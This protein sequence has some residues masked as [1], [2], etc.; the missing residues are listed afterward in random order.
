MC[1]LPVTF[2]MQIIFFKKGMNDLA[3]L[4]LRSYVKFLKDL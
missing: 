3:W 2:I 1:I 4:P